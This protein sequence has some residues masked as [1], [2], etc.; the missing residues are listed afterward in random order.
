[1][2][3]EA[4]IPPCGVGDLHRRDPHA[5]VAEIRGSRADTGAPA[6]DLAAEPDALEV[7]Y[8][9]R[10]D[11]DAGA[12]FADRPGLFVD[13]DAQAAREQRVGREQATDAPA[14][15]RYAGTVNPMR[16]ST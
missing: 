9:V 1:V 6:L 11:E 8:R 16:P 15:Y 4:G 12:D 7:T 10:R 5:V 2:H 14:D 13:G 3:A